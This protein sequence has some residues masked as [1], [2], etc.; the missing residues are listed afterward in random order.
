MRVQR[1]GHARFVRTVGKTK[2]LDEVLI[3]RDLVQPGQPVDGACQQLATPVGPIS[4]AFGNGGARR[5]H[6]GLHRIRQQQR[7][8]ETAAGERIAES[9]PAD[10]VPDQSRPGENDRRVHLGN[11]REQRRNRRARG[12]RDR[13]AGSA[14]AH[15]GDGRQRH[16]GVAQPVWREDDQ[17][18]HR[19]VRSKSPVTNERTTIDPRSRALAPSGPA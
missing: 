17:T 11:E 6:G 8:V 2:R 9:T 15:V 19:V 18:L 5:E 3:R 12:D 16:D 13:H 1:N 7:G 4:P 14:S 10:D